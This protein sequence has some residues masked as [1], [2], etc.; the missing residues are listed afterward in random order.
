MNREALKK[1]VNDTL[2]FDP[3]KFKYMLDE[4]H[5]D[6]TEIKG[7]M[8][9]ILPL[10]G[11]LMVESHLLKEFLKV[12]KLD[13]HKFI[14]ENIQRVIEENTDMTKNLRIESKKKKEKTQIETKGLQ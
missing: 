8:K 2:G 13:P 6:L 5:T 10:V 14:D 7:L 12:H 4:H 9:Q 1:A 3:E 11:Q